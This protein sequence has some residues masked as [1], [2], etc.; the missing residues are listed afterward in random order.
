MCA[1]LKERVGRIEGVK[2]SRHFITRGRELMPTILKQPWAE[3]K[4]T[5]RR[6]SRPVCLPQMGRKRWGCEKKRL[7]SKNGLLEISGLLYWPDDKY[8]ETQLA[9]DHAKRVHV[10]SD[11][12]E[13]RGTPELWLCWGKGSSAVTGTW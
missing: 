1:H 3:T 5:D 4:L 10:G 11:G 8:K 7:C 9:V 2:M 12:A 6:G 13:G